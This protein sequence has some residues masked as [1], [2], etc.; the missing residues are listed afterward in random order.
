MWF[1]VLQSNDLPFGFHILE[2]LPQLHGRDRLSRKS[3]RKPF[4]KQSVLRERGLS[5]NNYFHIFVRLMTIDAILTFLATIGPDG[6]LIANFYS[7]VE[8]KRLVLNE[9]L[10][11]EV[12]VAIL[13][14]LRHVLS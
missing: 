13:D 8:C 10:F 11:N 1:K 9:T 12:L 2:S 6:G 14:L 7:L 4:R 3:I 5:L